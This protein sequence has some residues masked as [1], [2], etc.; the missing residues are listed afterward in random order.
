VLSGQKND[1]LE[2]IFDPLFTALETVWVIFIADLTL[3]LIVAIFDDFLV[4]IDISLM[5]F[6]DIF[7]YRKSIESQG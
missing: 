7:D 4:I 5:N 6:D 3:L 2:T 1:P